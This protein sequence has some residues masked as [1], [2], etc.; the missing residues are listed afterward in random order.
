MAERAF[1]ISPHDASVS[2]TL[3]W[4]LLQQGEADRAVAYLQAANLSAPRDSDIQ[5]H[6]A[7]A[8]QRVGR[9][10]DARA[11]L[12]SLLGS[13]SPFADESEAEKLLQK[14]KRG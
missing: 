5:Y 2:D 8:L 3:G 1:T 11:M 10:G 12:E 9:A 7:V 4:I 6:L 14:L 13:G